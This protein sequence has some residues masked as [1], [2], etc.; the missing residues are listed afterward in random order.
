MRDADDPIANALLEAL[1]ARRAACDPLISAHQAALLEASVL[2]A[3]G[4]A[5]TALAEANGTS[6]HRTSCAAASLPTTRPKTK[7]DILIARLSHPQGV[8]VT[9]LETELGWS[10]GALSAS[11]S[12]LRRD[13]YV[14]TRHRPPGEARSHYRIVGKTNAD[15]R[16]R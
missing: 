12:N 14:I 8:S 1:S 3:L 4:K 13:G 16:S 10:Q 7:K 15:L 6:H 9:A 11:L 5:I 2:L